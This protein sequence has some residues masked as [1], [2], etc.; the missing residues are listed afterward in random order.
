M[1]TGFAELNGTRFYYEI[2]GAGRPLVLV[3][4]GIA[5]SRMWD[6][7][8]AVFAEQYQVIRYDRRGFG[9]TAMVAGPFSH[10]QDLHGLLHF[11]NI[12]RA[13]LVG[14]SQGG[15]T[16]LDFTLEHPQMTEALVLVGSALGGFAFSGERPRQAEELDAAEEAGDLERVNE[17]E[18]QIWVD[19]ASRTPD[20]VNPQVRELVRAMNLIALATPEGLGEEVPLEPAAATRLAE[21]RVPIMVIVGDVD[22]ARTL[23]TADYLAATI[24]GAQKVVMAGTAHVPNMEQPELFNAHVLNFLASVV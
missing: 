24:S 3:H 20:Q 18:L 9:K 15:K 22:T 21:I 12:G 6:S 8:F 11:L 7:Q 5:D 16:V 17:L 1:Q 13:L 4:A 14:C 10:H 19:G 23:A 2:A